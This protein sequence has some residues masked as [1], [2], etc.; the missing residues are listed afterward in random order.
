MD[1]KLHLEAPEK[2]ADAERHDNDLLKKEVDEAKAIVRNAKERLATGD[3]REAR[4]IV[5]NALDADASGVRRVYWL[6][7][8]ADVEFADNDLL[9]ARDWLAEAVAASGREPEA[10]AQKIRPDAVAGQIS[11]L[12]RNRLWRDALEVLEVVEKLPAEIRDTAE[13]RAA[14]GD[15]YRDCGCH[16]HASEGYSWRHDLRRSASWL[17]SG[18]PLAPIRKRI[19]NWEK[20]R[21]LPCL[22]Q[23]P[24]YIAQVDGVGLEDMQAQQLHLQLETLNYR[25]LSHWYWWSA[26]DRLRRRL[27][28]AGILPAWLVL[29]V[30]VHQAGFASGWGAAAWAAA[31]GVFIATS[32]FALLL[33]VLRKSNPRRLWALMAWFSFAVVLVAAAGEGFDRRM[34]PVGGW[35]SWVLLGLVVTLAA[36]PCGML[37]VMTF[38]WLWRRW[39]RKLSREN[40]PLV[41]LDLLLDVLDY[42]RPATGNR[43][44]GRRLA[45]AQELEYAA[46]RLTQ[47][48]LPSSATSGLGSRDWLIQRAAGWAEAWRHMQRQMVAS[49]PGDLTKLEELLVHEVR[50][51]AT[52]DMGALAW[53]EP[54]PPP[55]RLRQVITWARVI[56]VAGL[57]LAAVFIAQQF[58]RV[59]GVISWA[60]V[61]W[62]ALYFV[63]SLDPTIRDKVEVA[64]EIAGLLRTD[65]PP[66]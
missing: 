11:A 60:T 55:S 3:V 53:S 52:C 36:V 61:G 57:P 56:L 66:R 65:P 29:L 47:D 16:A 46:Q 6:L 49:A 9:A 14:V 30:V 1:G 5:R 51:L 25:Y 23:R 45:L 21:L 28:P 35:W 8:M 48:L 38:N 17:C 27:M 59:P 62:A 58:V 43:S 2:G 10:V 22:K 39:S 7:V 42:L 37:A 63:L 33:M 34:L 15:F 24:A 13:V 54:P 4:A 12:R 44:I 41:L 50:C 31:V 32:S 26:V 19:C 20:E 64:H 40:C 18:G